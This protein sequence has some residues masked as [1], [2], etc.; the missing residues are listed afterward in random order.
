MVLNDGCNRGFYSVRGT[1]IDTK[2]ETKYENEG[3]LEPK[4]KE[5]WYSSSDPSQSGCGAFM[6]HFSV[7]LHNCH[8]APSQTVDGALAAGLVDAY[9]GKVGPLVDE[10]K[11]TEG[12]ESGRGRRFDT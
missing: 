1:R 12:D 8:L 4:P 7:Y 6:S 11:R 3:Y 9:R 5:R 2:E 10:Y